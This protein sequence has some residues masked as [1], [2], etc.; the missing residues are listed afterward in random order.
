[1]YFVVASLSLPGSPTLKRV[2]SLAA[3]AAPFHRSTLSLVIGEGRWRRRG[4]RLCVAKA[5]PAC[6][7]K[8]A[9][10]F[11][12]AQPHRDVAQAPLR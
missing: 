8:A 10:V 2:S 5:A 6:G 12:N 7:C 11:E 4:R 1:M 3:H 9:Q